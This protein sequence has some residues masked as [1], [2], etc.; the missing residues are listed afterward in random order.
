MSRLLAR[1]CKVKVGT[2][3]VSTFLLEWMRKGKIEFEV[4][5]LRIEN[6]HL[7]KIIY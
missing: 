6:K 3:K 4:F 1:R 5:K 2:K 7:E